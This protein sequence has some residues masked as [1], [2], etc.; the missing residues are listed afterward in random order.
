M[1]LRAFVGY[2]G[3]SRGQLEGEIGQKAWLVLPPARELVEMREP[4]N[5]WQRVMRSSGPLMK[6]LAEAPDDPEK[7]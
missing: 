1:G 3:W 5:A 7:N 6:L 4:E 2:A